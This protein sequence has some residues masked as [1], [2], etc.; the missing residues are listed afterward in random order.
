[1]KEYMKTN[2]RIKTFL[3]AGGNST[4]LV[5]NCGENT[6]KQLISQYLGKVEQ[7]GFVQGNRLEMMGSELCINSTIAFASQLPEKKGELF[8]S[9]IKGAIKYS[10]SDTQ[11]TIELPIIAT[12][13]K[14][15][16]LLPGI[17][18]LCETKD[19]NITKELLLNFCQLYNLPAFGV[20]IYK[21]NQ[22]T[23]Y[24]Y[25]KETD[26]L[27][28][29]TACG[30]GSIAVSLFTGLQKIRQP[31]GACISVRI[32]KNNIAISAQVKEVKNYDILQKGN[33]MSTKQLPQPLKGFRDFLPDEA[34][35]RQWLRE[36]IIKVFELWGFD[37]LETP[38]L[39]PLDLFSGQIGEDEKLFFKFKDSGNRDVALRYDQTV[40]AC[41]VVA[42]YYQQLPMPF[43]RYQI[44]PAFRAE[45][46]QK[47][48]YREFVQCDADIFGVSSP[49]ADAE[50]IALSLDI[51]RK[52]G[53]PQA[54][55]LINDRQ[56]LKDLPYV[57]IVAI[58]K[59]K[60]IGKDGVIEEMKAKGISAEDAQKYLNIV[61]NLK[62]NETI[63]V[64]LNYLKEQ[65]LDP[66]WYEFDPTI[67]RSFSY[68]SGPIWEIEIPGIKG[69]VLGG[70]RFD[71]L[72][73]KIS[74]LKIPATGFG[75]GFDR[76]LEAAE[77]LGLL[78]QLKATAKVLV[79]VFS[80][81]L[82]SESLKV[83][84]ILRDQDVTTEV[85][86]EIKDKLSKQ[87]KYASKKG[88]PWTIVIGPEE[89]EKKIVQ[90]KNMQTEKQLEIV[91]S[92]LVSVVQ[93]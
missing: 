58:D 19:I 71:N 80:K 62:P 7:I 60:K 85:Y 52:I 47:G 8:T 67:A 74:G 27:I 68:S 81:E 2:V 17:G 29:E 45:K 82:L 84:N 23:P 83:A 9:G 33:S 69:S 65:G 78:P 6:R 79:T 14:N 64:I 55:V 92:E 50:V 36:K 53:F 48:R 72:I 87:F 77:E 40:P 35:K 46:P 90:L 39:E 61:L 44:Q 54:K 5:Q 4:L 49:I 32:E 11:T 15:I 86:T 20:A 31:T 26:S 43:K 42:Q 21:N 38:T 63:T 75:L 93:G 66:A 16:V 10:N 70:E 12:V 76:T 18:F 30:S 89:V 1:M 57:A 3:I 41:R 91:M 59:L 13:D 25:V 56:L 34:R 88:I 51:Y 73:E 37:P 22:L 24:V 28:K